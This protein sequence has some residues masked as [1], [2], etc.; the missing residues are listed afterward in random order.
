MY[1]KSD[2]AATTENRYYKSQA[3]QSSSNLPY[4]PKHRNHSTESREYY[5]ETRCL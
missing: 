3:C 5:R 1:T 4:V 2:A